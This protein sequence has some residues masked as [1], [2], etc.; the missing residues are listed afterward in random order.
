MPLQILPGRYNWATPSSQ[1]C[2]QVFLAFVFH[3]LFER[4]PASH[5]P[6]K[7]SIMLVPSN[8]AL[9]QRK[10]LACEGG[11]DKL[12]TATYIPLLEQIP[13]WHVDDQGLSIERKY[14]FKHF[15]A[16]IRFINAVAEL[17]EQEQHHPDLHLTGYRNVKIVLT[18]HAIGGLS[19]NDFIV[20]AKI[21]AMPS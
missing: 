12:T 21:D 17:A 18:T 5:F 6:Y 15:K 20:A 4:L 1:W 11:V 14:V 8:E 3:W 19:E 2:R 10:C 13:Q 9:V 7:K 16:A